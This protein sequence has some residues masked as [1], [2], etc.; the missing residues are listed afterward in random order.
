MLSNL[1]TSSR[2]SDARACPR[3]EHYKYGLGYRATQ[4]KPTLRFG[5]LIHAALEAWWLA[6]AG[7]KLRSAFEVLATA[8]V[9][10]YDLARAEVMLER[11]HHRWEAEPFEVLVANGRQCVEVQF[12]TELRNPATGHPSRT[13]RLA[14]KLDALVRDL[15]DGEVKVVEHKTS[16]VDISPGSD[17]FERLVMDA[18][19]S[20]YFDGA[21][22][23]GFKPAA[24]I[25]DVLGKPT[26]RPL[27]A[28]PEEERK[29]T[30]KATRLADGT[31]RPAGSLYAN[32]R[33]HDETPDEYRD[34]LRAAIAEAPDSYFRRAEVVRLE[35]ELDEARADHWFTGKRIHEYALA[36]YFPRNPDACF[37]WNSKCAFW[38]VCS[39]TARLDDEVMF[40]RSDVVHPE[41]DLVPAEEKAA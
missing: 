12:E 26:Q 30:Q 16:S 35:S 41:L 18:Q 28:T 14:G 5:T 22:A 7:W 24:V 4:D 32:Q 40:T 33:D 31:V 36:G 8:D 20:I 3:L 39:G 21:A 29:Y 38:P 17:Y 37:R 19:V 34:R 25:Y 27:K 9:D 10:P 2:Q 11:Y 6:P 23:L 15:K 13:W 1:L